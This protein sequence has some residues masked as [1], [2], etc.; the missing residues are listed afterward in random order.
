MRHGQASFGTEEY[1]RLSELGC[2]QAEVLG[3]YFEHRDLHFDAVYTGELRRQ[4]KM[5]ASL[6]PG[7]IAT[8]VGFGIYSVLVNVKVASDIAA[9]ELSYANGID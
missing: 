7:F 4:R 8:A 5:L 9:A 1:D 6:V 3:E 2:R